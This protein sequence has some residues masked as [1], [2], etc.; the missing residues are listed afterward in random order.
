MKAIEIIVAVSIVCS[1]MISPSYANPN[2]S[3]ENKDKLSC[4]SFDSSKISWKYNGQSIANGSKY[5]ITNQ[6]TNLQNISSLYINNITVA[7]EGLYQ[8]VQDNNKIS[9]LTLTGEK[10]AR[11]TPLV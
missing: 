8:C 1:S 6:K 10:Q 9:N 2:I 4:Q 11:F 3:K 5:T 7:D